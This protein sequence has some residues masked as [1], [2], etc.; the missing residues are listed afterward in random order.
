MGIQN[1][2]YFCNCFLLH[3]EKFFLSIRILCAIDFTQIFVICND[4][5]IDVERINMYST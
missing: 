3:S 2:V 4:M 5:M 1:N